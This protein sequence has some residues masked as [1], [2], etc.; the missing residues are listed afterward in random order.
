V[1]HR[2]TGRAHLSSDTPTHR[3]DNAMPT[4]TDPLADAAESAAAL[5]GLAHATR[6]MPPTSTYPVLGELIAGTRSLRQVLDQL[7]RSLVDAH[8]LARTDDG[9]PFLGRVYALAAADALNLAANA[10]DE[11]QVR[12]DLA[13]Q[14]A[15]RIAWQPA[16]L[17]PA[18]LAGD[19]PTHAPEEAT[20]RWVS[21]VFL[22]GEEA[23]EVLTLIDREGPDAAVAHLARWDYGQETTDAAL[24]NGYVY[25]APPVG[26]LDRTVTVEGY[27]LTYNPTLGH[28]GLLR[29]HDVAPE[30]ALA[31]P[32]P[33]TQAGRGRPAD[34][35]WFGAA[36][37]AARL[38]QG[39]AL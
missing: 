22:Q 25:D 2:L 36:P 8:E 16:S 18:G 9:D 38:G 28:V 10:L 39:L 21:V 26:A 27:A 30:P 23:D 11:V 15:S 24:V 20:S 14:H 7:T 19:A 33:L 35:E 32:A 5:R 6:D 29:A 1:P 31:E 13:S 34:P 17:D 12:L 4:L 37:Q 3:E